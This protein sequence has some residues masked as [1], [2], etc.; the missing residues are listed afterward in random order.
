MWMQAMDGRKK[1]SAFQ[2]EPPGKF[3]G[4]PPGAK[5]DFLGQ[6]FFG[7]IIFLSKTDFFVPKKFFF[8]KNDFFGQIIFLYKTDFFG[9]IFSA[10]NIYISKNVF[11]GQEYLYMQKCFFRPK[12]IIA[13]KNYFFEQNLFLGPQRFFRPKRLFWSKFFS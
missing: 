12:N 10:K 5:N 4:K 7:E 2:P 9:Q 11:F 6:R 13:A 8:H 3:P 1:T